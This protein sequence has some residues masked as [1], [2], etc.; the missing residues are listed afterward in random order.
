MNPSRTPNP[1]ETICYDV[2]GWFSA[3]SYE[4]RNTFDCDWFCSPVYDDDEYKEGDTRCELYGAEF[5][6]FGYTAN[7]ACC[8]KFFT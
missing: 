5:P 8:C 2:P 6:N 3:D 7:E 1:T 4:S